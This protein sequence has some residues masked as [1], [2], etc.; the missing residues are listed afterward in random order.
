[1]SSMA[2]HLWLVTLTV[3][4]FVAMDRELQV[5]AGRLLFSRMPICEHM[6]DPP[7]CSQAPNLICGTDGLTYK[8]ECHL[9]ITRMKTRKD[10]QIIKDGKC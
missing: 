2:M 3:V 5:S 1:M 7:N 6:A 4:S 9:C 10:I 8:N